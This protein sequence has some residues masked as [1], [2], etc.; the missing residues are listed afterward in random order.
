MLTRRIRAPQLGQGGVY[1]AMGGDEFGPLRTR[2]G[3][4]PFVVQAGAAANSQPPT[5]GAGPLPVMSSTV[6]GNLAD[7]NPLK[8][9]KAFFNCR[10][11]VAAGCH[12]GTRFHAR[13]Q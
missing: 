11:L 10:N 7:S 5:P 8:A 13:D 6:T 9:N 2:H 12:A 4:A 1:G 3:V